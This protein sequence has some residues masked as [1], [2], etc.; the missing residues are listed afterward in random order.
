VRSGLIRE[1]TYFFISEAGCSLWHWN[2]ESRGATGYGPDYVTLERY[3]QFAGVTDRYLRDS[4]EAWLVAAP[5]FWQLVAECADAE[6][7]AIPPE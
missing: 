3:L 4:F 1:T 5:S 6:R 2:M 7:E